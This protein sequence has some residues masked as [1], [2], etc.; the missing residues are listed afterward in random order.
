MRLHFRERQR[1]VSESKAFCRSA[2][3]RIVP[4]RS[5]SFRIVP[6]SCFFLSWLR[7]RKTTFQ[8]IEQ[9]STEA[10]KIHQSY[11]AFTRLL[12]LS[13][14]FE[15]VSAGNSKGCYYSSYD[16]LGKSQQATRHRLTGCHS[17]HRCLPETKKAETWRQQ[18]GSV[19]AHDR[20]RND[21]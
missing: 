19:L 3:F 17:H 6:H 2:S 7:R 15:S 5:A 9:C 21:I 1:D 8:R 20:Q 4:H 16:I 11:K 12:V 10:S 14:R 18:L 13:S